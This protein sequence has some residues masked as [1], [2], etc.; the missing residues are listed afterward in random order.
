MY[1]YPLNSTELCRWFQGGARNPEQ[2]TPMNLCQG[3]ITKHIHYFACPTATNSARLSDKCVEGGKFQHGITN[4][5]WVI[6][7]DQALEWRKKAK[8]KNGTKKEKYRPA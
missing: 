5:L 1:S 3:F 6:A 7:W 2:A 4:P 8:K